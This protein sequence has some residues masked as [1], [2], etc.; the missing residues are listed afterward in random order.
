MDTLLYLIQNYGLWFVFIAVLLDQGGIPVPAYPSII[1]ASALT[2]QAGG[3]LWPLVLVAVVAALGADLLWYAGG[4]R[5]GGRLIRLMCR[6]SLS[7][8]SCVATTRG[9]YLRWGAPALV[10]AKFVPGF[11]AI[12]TTLAGQLRTRLVRFAFYDG[13]GALLWATVAV[14]LGAVFHEAVRGVLAQLETLGRV[15]LLLVL[16][17]IILWVAWKV[18]ERQRFMRLIRMARI[19]VPELQQLLAAG[20]GPLLLDVRPAGLREASGWIP[21]AVRV[22][23]VDELKLAPQAEVVVYCDCPN[24][25][26]AAMLARELKQRGFARVRPLAGGFA[27]WQVQGLPIEH[28]V[29][30]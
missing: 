10:V 17:S 1:L 19:S 11:A 28:A 13:I 24:E 6:L 2:V 20:K 7:P 4:R 9:F 25:A 12:A 21:G 15:G 14:V 18:W 8:D 26:S 16:G 23:R 5:F 22:S 3:S 30:Q 29:P 27:A